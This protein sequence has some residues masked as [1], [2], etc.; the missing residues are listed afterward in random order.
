MDS[1]SHKEE[2]ARQYVDMVKVLERIIV[3]R[4]AVTV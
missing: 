2:Y 1:M 3:G 4:F